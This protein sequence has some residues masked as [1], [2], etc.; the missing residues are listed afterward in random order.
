M[1]ED[2]LLKRNDNT[3]VVQELKASQGIY[4]FFET[5]VDLFMSAKLKE[6]TYFLKWINATRVKKSRFVS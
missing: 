6:T 5:Q 2:T 3:S 1:A 4:A